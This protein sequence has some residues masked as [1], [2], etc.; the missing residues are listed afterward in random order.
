MSWSLF[1]EGSQFFGA[2]YKK[3]KLN[4]RIGS[5]SLTHRHGVGERIFIPRFP[6][7]SLYLS[8]SLPLC[9]SPLPSLP[10]QDT[11][12]ISAVSTQQ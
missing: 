10:V 7:P 12:N 4:K 3:K 9:V 1:I 2:H 6:L 11:F 5:C 8:L